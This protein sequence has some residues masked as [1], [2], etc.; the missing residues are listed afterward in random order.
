MAQKHS[1]EIILEYAQAG[2][3]LEVRAIDAFDGLEVAFIVPAKTA[4]PEIKRLA[5][6]KLNYVRSRKEKNKSNKNPSR[7]DR[8]G[9][10]N[11]RI[12]RKFGV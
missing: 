9:A 1:Q 11:S 6:S 4:D 5:I 10:W 3:S 7:E 8:N 12:I 2:N